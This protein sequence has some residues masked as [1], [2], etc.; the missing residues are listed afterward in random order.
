MARIRYNDQ[1]VANHKHCTPPTSSRPRNCSATAYVD[2]K[3]QKSTYNFFEPDEDIRGLTYFVQPPY[4][5]CYCD[6]AT[7]GRWVQC[8]IAESLCNPNMLKRGKMGEPTVFKGEPVDVIT[9]SESLV[10]AS[11]DFR[12]YVEQNT[13]TPVQYYTTFAEGHANL[14][15]NEVNMTAFAAGRPDASVFVVPGKVSG[16][17][18]DQM[19]TSYARNLQAGMHPIAAWTGW[20]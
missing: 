9:W 10:V 13:T 6:M 19:C 2:D 11:T 14:G 5:A 8:E 16:V 12:I 7:L 1:V 15:F 17:C 20:L 3:A 18:D 4:D